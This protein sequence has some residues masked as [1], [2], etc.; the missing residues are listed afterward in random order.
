MEEGARRAHS[1]PVEDGALRVGDAL[2]DLAVV[3]GVAGDARLNCALDEGITQWVAPVDVGDG[4]S[5]VAAAKDRI[6]VAD[7]PFHAPEIGEHVG[8]APAAVAELRP[9]VEV[10]GLATVVDVAVDGARAAE[11]LAAWGKDAPPARPRARLHAVEP[12]HARIMVGLDEAGGDVDVGV[13]ITRACL[14]DAHRCLAVRG[15]SVG[16]HATGRA[17]A[18]DDVVISLHAAPP[19]AAYAVSNLGRH[20]SSHAASKGQSL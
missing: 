6:A 4:E 9:G 17:C 5:S 19:L 16:E 14:E 2:L 15:Q 13:P 8:I 12:V 20:L 3:V 18:N 10:H 1:P 7:A 11:C